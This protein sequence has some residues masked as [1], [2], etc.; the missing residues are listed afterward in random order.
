MNVLGQVF[1]AL[2]FNKTD[3]ALNLDSETE[4]NGGLTF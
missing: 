4:V 3:Q 2:G 1:T